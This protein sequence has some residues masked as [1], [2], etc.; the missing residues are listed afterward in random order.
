[1]H[2][3]F[4]DDK[5]RAEDDSVADISQNEAIGSATSDALGATPRLA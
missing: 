1:M 3:F 4:G 2:L 5:R